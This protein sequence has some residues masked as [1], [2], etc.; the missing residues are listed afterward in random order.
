[1]PTYA[2][3]HTTHTQVMQVL[4]YIT[5]NT[6]GVDDVSVQMTRRLSSYE[7]RLLRT[8]IF[9]YHYNHHAFSRPRYVRLRQYR[10]IKAVP[11]S[12]TYWSCYYSSCCRCNFVVVEVLAVSQLSLSH[13]VERNWV[14]DLMEQS[15]PWAVDGYSSGQQSSCFEELEDTWPCSAELLSAKQSTQRSRLSTHYRYCTSE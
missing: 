13:L 5:V 6:N 4:I 7:R 2:R 9:H 8:Q 1:M 14:I 11:C 3:T 10:T 15:I 12:P